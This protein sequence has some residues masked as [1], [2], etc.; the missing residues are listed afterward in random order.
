MSLVA[1]ALVGA[2]AHSAIRARRRGL[3]GGLGAGR[4]PGDARAAERGGAGALPAAAVPARV[5][6]G[7]GDSDARVDRPGRCRE[8]RGRTRDGAGGARDA[9]VRQPARRPAAAGTDDSVDWDPSLVFPE[10]RRG[11]RLRRSSLPPTRATLHSRDGKVLA[12]GPAPSRTSPLI[13]IAD[14]VAGQM[15][16]AGD[17]RGAEG[18]LR[19]RLPT[20]LAGRADR[21]G[22]GVRDAPPRAARRR[23]DRGQPRAGTREAAR[24]RRRS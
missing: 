6:A 15:E 4:I 13:G 11:E 12:E 17:R 22:G 24:G 19:A 18:S 14:S 8:V 21:P 3:H 16:P 10:L 5:R 2:G 23:A 7:R 1:G 9:R 20:R